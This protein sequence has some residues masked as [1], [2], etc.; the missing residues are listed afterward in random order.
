MPDEKLVKATVARG[1]S[2]VV[3]QG[4][5]VLGFD[6]DTGKEIFGPTAFLTFNENQEIELTASDV[7]FQRARGYLVDPDST[8]PLP[9]EGP[10][11]VQ[12]GE[13]RPGLVEQRS[14]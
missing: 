4:R 12:R 14:H 9:P 10:T 13:F 1:R 5:K 7:A 6:K 3:G 8:V 2:I 11:V